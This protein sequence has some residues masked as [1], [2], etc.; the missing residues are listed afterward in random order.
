M[1]IRVSAW[2]GL[3]AAVCT[4]AF[5]KAASAEAAGT[6]APSVSTYDTRASSIV[7]AYRHGFSNA[8]SFNTFSYN[9][10]FTSTTG[11]LSAQFG[12]HYVNF[13]QTGYDTRAHGVGGS[14]V[15]VLEYPVAG[16]W[17]DGVPKAALAFHLGS[18]PTAYI[19]G[20]RNFL[21]IPFVLGF[22]VPLSPHK[23]VTFT[24]W[25]ELAISANV[26]TIVRPEGVT[27]DSSVVVIDPVTQTASLKP[28]AVEAALRQGV[29]IDVGVSVPMRAGLQGTLHLGRSADVDLY[30]MLS[31]L[32]GAFSGESVKT[33]GAAL[34]VRWDDIVPAVLPKAEAEAESC[35]A[36]ERRFRACPNSRHWL[37]PEQRGQAPAAVVEPA[38]A[39]APAPAPIVTPPAPPAASAPQTAPPPAPAPAPDA[40][41]PPTDSFPAP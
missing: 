15:A 11:R 38:P 7:F 36:T 13:K 19:S 27:I 29:T 18:V 28:G 3:G 40:P 30:G 5:G 21:T 23:M 12:I 9:A 10:N 8:G 17:E 32:G 41:P 33:L 4:F 26:D 6:H 31:T 2:L 16:R 24:P 35:E 14:G 39:P 22:G 1:R 20:E 37:T 34:T 25:Y